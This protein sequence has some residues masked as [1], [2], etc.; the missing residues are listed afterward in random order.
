M[1]ASFV[2]V[3][4]ESVLCPV[5]PWAGHTSQACSVIKHFI[6]ILPL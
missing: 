1:T 4:C 6:K 2:E 3:S 5:K